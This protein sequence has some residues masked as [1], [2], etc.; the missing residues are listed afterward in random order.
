MKFPHGATDI[1]GVNCPKRLWGLNTPMGKRRFVGI[2]E[3]LKEKENIPAQMGP[4]LCNLMQRAGATAHGASLLWGSQGG[5][6]ALWFGFGFVL[7]SFL[8]STQ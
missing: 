6:V 1:S 5:A 7:C 3:F 8:I 4:L 2:Y